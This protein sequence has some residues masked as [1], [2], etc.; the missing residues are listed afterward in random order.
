[1]KEKIIAAIAAKFPNAKLSKKRLEQIAAVILEDVIDDEAKIDAA[2]TQYNRYNNLESLGK[3]DADMRGLNKKV[4][5]L[6]GTKSTKT[7]DGKQA[8][9]DAGKTGSVDA[10]GEEGEAIPAWAKGLISSVNG[11]GSTVAAMQKKE[12]LGTVL[13]QLKTGK[14]KDV[15]ASFWEKRPIPEKEE[16]IEAFA[17]EVT[18]DFTVFATEHGIK[19]STGTNGMRPPNAGGPK[20][21][22]PTGGA[23]KVDAAVDKFF[24]QKEEA[25]KGGVIKA[26]APIGGGMIITAGTR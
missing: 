9:S 20:T 3:A 18:A 19:P 5:E 24:K 11:I 23:G 17:T 26:A 22:A 16:D 25:G 15:P 14:L 8:A 4:T 10:G 7:D 2:I 13:D 1:M 21:A 12:K 6:E